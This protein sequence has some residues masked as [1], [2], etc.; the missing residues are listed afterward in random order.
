MKHP[1]RRTLALLLVV[2]LMFSSVGYTQD[3]LSQKPVR[4][5]MAAGFGLPR[6][7]LS[8]FRSPVSILGGGLINLGLMPRVRTQ[9]NA[10]GLYT[11]NLGRI[12]AQEGKL[13]FNLAWISGELM[14]RLLGRYRGESFISAG[15]GFYDLSQQ[16]G[17]AEDHIQ[18]AGLCLGIA[19]W[20]GRGSKIKSLVEVKWHLLFKPKDG[21]PQILT[22]TL[23]IFLS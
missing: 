18:T 20:M 11:F 9:I 1:K 16:F 3:R 15:M 6:V 5:G 2:I 12:D 4:F 17:L 19:Q 22:V 21:L 7:P 8:P 13:R 23:G 14:Y 10:Y